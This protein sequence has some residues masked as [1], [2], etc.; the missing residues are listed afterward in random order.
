MECGARSCNITDTVWQEDD[1]TYW[2]E[3]A[4]RRLDMTSAPRE[5][6]HAAQASAG[7]SELL[8]VSLMQKS[9]NAR[10]EGGKRKEMLQIC[11]QNHPFL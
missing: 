8:Q 6:T 7:S 1:L 10:Q 11:T 9:N 5:N 2:Q 3:E 4:Y